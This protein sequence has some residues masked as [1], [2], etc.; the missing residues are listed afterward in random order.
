MKPV[1]GGAFAIVDFGRNGRRFDINVLREGADDVIR[2][3]T[4]IVPVL[5]GLEL[6]VPHVPDA[7]YTCELRF[8]PSLQSADL[9]VDGTQRL[10]G[11]RGHAEFQEDRGVSFGAAPYGSPRAAASFQHVRFEIRP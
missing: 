5:Q 8:D 10:A 7:F 3:N 4:R 9:W 1:E 11:Y 6:R 2:L